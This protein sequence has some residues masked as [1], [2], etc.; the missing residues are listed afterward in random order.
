MNVLKVVLSALIL[1]LPAVSTAAITQTVVTS[2]SADTD[3]MVL[4]IEGL[5][6]P[7]K[8]L[9]FMGKE[10][11]G[12]ERLTINAR[13]STRIEANLKSS[14]PG[15]FLVAVVKSSTEYFTSTVTIPGVAGQEI[16]TGYKWVTTNDGEA[17]IDCPPGKIVVGGG[18]DAYKGVAVYQSYAHDKNTWV[19]RA[20]SS[21]PYE[22]IPYAIC[23]TSSP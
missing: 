15:T 20:T 18:Y 9:V 3:S 16:V 8:A 2:T 17:F 1:S 14:L 23:A 5:N 7:A 10:G 11:G 19:V 21:N 6:L 12:L 22:L 4:S 13:S